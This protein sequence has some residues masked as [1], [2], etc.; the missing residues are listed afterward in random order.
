MNMI[1]GQ[2]HANRQKDW[3]NQR[4]LLQFASNNNSVGFPLHFRSPCLPNRLHDPHCVIPRPA[5]QAAFIAQAH[6]LCGA[7]I[8]SSKHKPRSD[9]AFL[10]LASKNLA[11]QT[12]KRPRSRRGKTS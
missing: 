6:L 9:K 7:R 5:L 1:R 4:Q 3:H 12:G 2:A 8:Q 11:S 10:W